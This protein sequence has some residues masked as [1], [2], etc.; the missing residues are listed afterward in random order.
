MEDSILDL[1]LMTAIYSKKNGNGPRP[2]N[3]DEGVSFWS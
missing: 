1:S 2:L 3:A